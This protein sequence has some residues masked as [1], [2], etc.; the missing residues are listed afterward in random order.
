MIVGQEL[1]S[2]VGAYKSRTPGDEN[3]HCRYSIGNTQDYE[4]ILAG[5]W[6]VKHCRSLSA[7]IASKTISHSAAAWFARDRDQVMNFN[8]FRKSAPDTTNR[9]IFRAALIVGVFGL[10]A[11]FA[12]TIKEL[13]IARSFG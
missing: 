1:F 4:N 7:I 6:R 9:K 12:A 13:I 2:E 10:T 3:I 11:K 8:L 5:A